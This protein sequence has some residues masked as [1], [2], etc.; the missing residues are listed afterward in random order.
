MPISLKS[1]EVDVLVDQVTSL[2]GESKTEAI[3]RA[4][5]ERRDR[6]TRTESRSKNALHVF[7]A[8]EIW[9][10]VPRSQFRWRLGQAETD[11][12]FGYDTEGT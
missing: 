12:A 10:L 11:Q 1:A 9:P 4:L 6:L 5:M 3:R 7:L 2:T 8:A